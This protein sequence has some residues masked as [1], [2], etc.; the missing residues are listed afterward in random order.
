MRMAGSRN[1]DDCRPVD[2]RAP[3]RAP[4]LWYVSSRCGATQDSRTTMT[5]PTARAEVAGD[6]HAGLGDPGDLSA[7]P[8]SR[9]WATAV[10]GELIATLHNIRFYADHLASMNRLM[11]EHDG[12]KQLYDSRGQPFSDYAAFCVEPEPWGLG[13]DQQRGAC[14]FH[15][16]DG[17]KALA[18]AFNG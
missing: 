4:S 5:R 3:G 12:Y 7:P 13:M 18:E 17:Y 15:E 9:P 6:A 11:R 16:T 1:A 14:G 8:G 2:E 10:R